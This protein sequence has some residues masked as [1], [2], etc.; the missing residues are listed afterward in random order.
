MEK[1]SETDHVATF[2]HYTSTVLKYSCIRVVLTPLDRGRSGLNIANLTAGMSIVFRAHIQH[3]R[4]LGQRVDLLSG[5]QVHFSSA[6]PMRFGDAI[7]PLTCKHETEL[8]CSEGVDSLALKSDSVGP[9][10]TVSWSAI[11]SNGCQ[12]KIRRLAFPRAINSPTGVPSPLDLVSSMG[13]WETLKFFPPPTICPR[14]SS[15]DHLILL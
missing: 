10:P 13:S 12:K 6:S 8:A 4:L 7:N 15:D 11:H 5:C 14:S 1:L 2:S 9:A 3:L